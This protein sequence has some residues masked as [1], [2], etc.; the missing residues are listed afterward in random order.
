MSWERLSESKRLDEMGAPE[1]ARLVATQQS[2]VAALVA[3]AADRIGRAAEAIED[4][5]SHGGRLAYAG[6]GRCGRTAASD[7]AG[8]SKRFGFDR[9]RIVVITKEPGQQGGLADDEDAI[10]RVNAQLRPED[11]LVCVS[12]SGDQAFGLNAA[13][14]ANRLGVLTIGIT[15]TPN[16][17]LAS[18]CDFPIVIP[19]GAEVV[20]GDLA[21]RSATAIKIALD[22][23]VTTAMVRHGRVFSNLPV[24]R[25]LGADAWRVVEAACGCS[26]IAA[27]SAVNAAGSAKAAIVMLR[28]GRSADEARVRLADA[29]GDVRRALGAN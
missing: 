26:P 5:L 15:T 23:L 11:A 20:M 27:R 4:R 3:A 17:S 14:A 21:L 8:L 24:E 6:W 16:S 13:R 28:L 25:D 19:T 9:A 10:T 1:V 29:G 7:A 2:D 18:E 22:A 12:A